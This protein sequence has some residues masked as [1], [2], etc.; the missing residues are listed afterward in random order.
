MMS[1]LVKNSPSEVSDPSADVGFQARS[2]VV[3]ASTISS[4]SSGSAVG[5]SPEI[6]GVVSEL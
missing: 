3:S 5:I 1:L 2:I 4:F 6:A